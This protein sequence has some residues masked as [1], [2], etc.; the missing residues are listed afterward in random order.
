MSTWALPNH[1]TSE[2]APEKPDDGSLYSTNAVGSRWEIES[3]DYFEIAGNM[4]CKH[5]IIVTDKSIVGTSPLEYVK[6]SFY[7]SHLSAYSS[8]DRINGAKTKLENTVLRNNT[9]MTA[10]PSSDFFL[11]ES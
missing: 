4:S 3:E 5:V 9:G 11:N 1:S 10:L 8:V 6:I 7:S 2:D